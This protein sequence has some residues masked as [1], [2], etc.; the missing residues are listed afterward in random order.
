MSSHVP[1]SEALRVN[2]D[3]SRFDAPVSER[4]RPIEDVMERF[5][6]L[7]EGLSTFLRELSHPMR[8]WG[9]IVAETRSFALSYFY[10]MK[11][12]RLGPTAA[13]LYGEI[14]LEA[15]ERARESDVRHEA[16]KTLQLFWQKILKDAG[17]ELPGF[18][19]ALE[20]GFEILTDL[21][22]DQFTV[23]ARGYYSLSSLA[24]LYLGQT[25]E[26]AQS[27]ALNRLMVRYLSHSYAYWLSEKDPRQWFLEEAGTDLPD[28]LDDLFVPI[29]HERLTRHQQALEET[30][31]RE[32]PVRTRLAALLQLPGFTD[33]RAAYERV[34]SEVGRRVPDEARAHRHELLLLFLIMNRP[35]LSLIHEESLRRINRVIGW[36]V[37][38]QDFRE[39]QELIRKTLGILEQ[40]VRSYPDTVLVCVLNLGRGVYRTDN[41]DLV[42]FFN[43]SV[44]NLGFQTPD[45]RGISRDWQVESNVAHI[46][47][48]RTWMELVKLNPR[49]SKNLLSSLV[50]H[51]SV[52]GVL[53]KDTDLFPRD[54]TSFLNGDIGQVYNLAKQLL[55]LFP[56][57]FNQIGAE[58]QLRDISTRI[59]EACGRRDVL[60]H[61]LRKQAHV[62]SSSETVGLMEAVLE[63]WRTRS[64]EGL[65]NFLPADVF[66]EVRERGPYVDGVHEVLESLMTSQGLSAVNDL[67][68]LEVDL[69]PELRNRFGRERDLDVERVALAVSFYRQLSEKYCTG[70]C[71]IHDYVNQAMD[72]G[73]PHLEALRGSL[74]EAN[75]YRRLAGLLAYLKELKG[76]I[77][78]RREFEAHEDIYHKRHFS[79]D[80]PSMYGSYHEPKFDALALTLRLE[81]V[82]NA[83]FEDGVRNLDLEFI[84]RATFQEIYNYLV[85]F[86]EALS[87]DGISTRE[88]DGQL[89]L[90]ERAL[91]V[92][93]FTFTQYV[94]IFRGF[95][96]VVQNILSDYFNKIHRHN[97]LRIVDRI[98]QDRLLPKYRHPGARSE[99]LFH[100]VSETFMRDSI[101]SSLGLQRLDLFLS[102]ILSTLYRQADKLPQDRHYLL[103][104][105]N[106]ED[107]VM[108]VQKAE[109]RL[110]DIVH[111]GNKGMNLVRMSELG[112]PVPPA[113]IVTTEVFTC[114]ELVESYAPAQKHFRARV[115]EQ[116]SL[117]EKAT[118]KRF[119]DPANPLVVSVRSGAAVSHP[120]MMDSYLNVGTNEEIVTGMVGLGHDGWFAWDC[121][122]R[123]LQSYGMSYGIERDE[124]DR[125]I[126]EHKHRCGVPLK[127]NFTPGQMQEV[128][129]GYRA[130]IE[131][132]GLQVPDDPREQL[133][134]AIQ[135]VLNS[136]NSERARA[137]R[138]IMGISDDWG[139]SVTV[140]AMIF[141]NLSHEAGSGVMF[142]HNP[143][144]SVDL[145]R[146]WGDYTVGNQGED[147]VSGLVTTFPISNYQ[148]EMENRS[149]AQTLENRF[150]KIYGAL[151]DAARVLTYDSGW[152]PQDMEFTFEGPEASRLY[153][154][155]TRDMEMR[156]RKQ[157]PTFES[158]DAMS[159]QFLGHGLGVAG[160]ALSGRAVF[161]LEDIEHWR[162]E[163]P[164]TKLILIRGDTVPDDIREVS[165]ADGLL[166]ARGG[167]TSHAAIVASRL[168]KTC[169]VGCTD[170]VCL[171]KER[172][173]VLG[174]E[175]VMVGDAISIDGAGGA[176]YLGFMKVREEGF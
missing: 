49:W 129:R 153:L 25:D 3:K 114:R 138:K 170:L 110:K 168:G 83:L 12:H 142:T 24:E 140:Q 10:E 76:L 45:F 34:P 144:L 94:D 131:G 175:V 18:L 20:Q 115:A 163:E 116:I 102:R 21:P 152:S 79:V 106:P 165:A 173:F 90:L 40:S 47:N 111:L 124:F 105:Y 95:T 55:R 174:Q 125:I 149:P 41:S 147:V 118:G 104:T 17:E 39:I 132:R 133:H 87:V 80:I 35:G 166:T 107:V 54:I 44:V 69:V 121:Y 53:I 101:A 78:S 148:A 151:L 4:Y 66:D 59:D 137:Y 16:A 160:G 19:P 126:E 31:H 171:Q 117:I 93:L 48:I 98:T 22:E 63:F 88:F 68:T 145:I 150:P 159:R 136:W 23:F 146:P 51:L 109:D 33:I 82:V 14:L 73:L 134:V 143:Q 43:E 86:S 157:V 64:R 156:E 89:T 122:R 72:S 74:D 96:Q 161:N 113:F 164:E 141:G 77:L 29:S 155:Q 158:A 81:V 32:G 42:N 84:T 7:Q 100:Q 92:R 27:P 127:K 13:Q 60:V 5:Q 97:L 169:V 154:L 30:L 119:G 67:L 162:R 123:F 61:F 37:G 9:F 99:E 103:L 2:I 15:V 130:F 71:E 1:S 38:H 58:G 56:S 26:T 70:F 85:L 6:G 62:E 108:S 135:Q 11:E 57:Y 128:A 91:R 176:V 120:G 28:T 139:T 112:L 36:L 50:I 172:K 167:A 52:S 65:R 46:R 75:P 8:N